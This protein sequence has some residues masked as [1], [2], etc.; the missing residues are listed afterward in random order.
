MHRKKIKEE[1]N[2]LG[3]VNK[4][5]SILVEEDLINKQKYLIY[6]KYKTYFELFTKEKD[7]NHQL[8]KENKKLYEQIISEKKKTHEHLVCKKKTKDGED[9]ENGE[10]NDEDKENE[11]NITSDFKVD[12]NKLEFNYNEGAFDSSIP[13][14]NLTNKLAELKES[15]SE[16][17]R[18]II[19]LENKI[20][21]LQILRRSESNVQKVENEPTDSVGLEEEM[22]DLKT[23]LEYQRV[24]GDRQKRELSS[25]LRE[26]IIKYEEMGMKY[27]NA[28]EQL[29][30]SLVNLENLR[31]FH[32]SR[33]TIK[34]RK[35]TLVNSQI[36]GFEFLVKD[37]ENKL[38]SLKV[39]YSELL[40]YTS[41][42]EKRNKDL[43]ER[44]N[45][46]RLLSERL[47]V[48]SGDD[49]YDQ[50]ISNLLEACDT[51]TEENKKLY[52]E[53]NVCQSQL[54]DYRRK[55]QSINQEV[56]M[57]KIKETTFTD[58]M[59]KYLQNISELTETVQEHCRKLE[60]SNEERN[61][62]TKLNIE[63]ISLIEKFK[64]DL[65]NKTVENGMLEIQYKEA[66]KQVDDYLKKF[67]DRVRCRKP[68]QEGNF[69]LC[70][71]CDTNGKNVA[72]TTCMHTFCDECIQT[73]I[74]FRNRRCPTCAAPFGTNDVKKFY[75]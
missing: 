68:S 62:L 25:K 10:E 6:L 29:T 1:Y 37:L 70:N 32:M 18:K 7:K 56:E 45:N 59:H 53:L 36:K 9:K 34:T 44:I 38:Y 30:H 57:H 24:D 66:L 14:E 46:Y 69:I 4:L 74:K 27:N 41:F 15:I 39:V 54:E 40:E 71:L 17:D 28:Y 3:V 67:E 63:R 2:H 8:E 12:L 23:K 21:K 5:K 11:N 20:I 51:L 65:R 48:K 61:K 31:K 49:F 52:L 22:I 64:E 60:E 58:D 26:Y 43:H 35:V 72:L 13:Q 19:E 75:I 55:Q 42:V 50:E 33:D 73:R 16:K 47:I